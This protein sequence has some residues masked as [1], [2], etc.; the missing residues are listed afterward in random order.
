LHTGVAPG[1]SAS[2]V[3]SATQVCEVELQTGFV[4]SV[5]SAVVLQP[6]QVFVLVSHVGVGAT[7]WVESVAVH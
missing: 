4:G 6:T 1:H 5:Q 7:Q 3:Q 2:F